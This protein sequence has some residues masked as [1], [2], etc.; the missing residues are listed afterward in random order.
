VSFLDSN[1]VGGSYGP[2]I[3]TVPVCAA[4][5]SLVFLCCGRPSLA[6]AGVC[7][8]GERAKIYGQRGALLPLQSIVP[9]D[10]WI[11]FL[12]VGYREQGSAS[13]LLTTNFW[14]PAVPRSCPDP[15]LFDSSCNVSM[16]G[17]RG[18]RWERVF[19]THETLCHCISIR[20]FSVI[21]Y[22]CA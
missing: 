17:L 12:P 21:V 5:L 22:E 7:L 18:C 15:S 2:V 11:V 6:A 10:E 19:S 3:E 16:G 8:V 9:R 20:R 1:I 4:I 13:Q 14:R